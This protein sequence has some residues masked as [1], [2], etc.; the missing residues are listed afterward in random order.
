MYMCFVD[1]E[2][3][4]DRVNH[5]KLWQ[6]MVDMG[7]ASHLVALIRSLYDNQRSNV[8]IHGDTSGWFSAKQGVRQGC[9]LSPY[10]FNLMA[11]LLMR[12]TLEGFDGDY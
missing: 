6:T 1:F 12:Y 7:F 4:F 3:A 9:I 5:N 11:E 10:L 8:R 2:K